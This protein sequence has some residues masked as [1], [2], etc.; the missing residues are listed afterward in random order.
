MKVLFVSSGNSEFFE[1]APFIKSQGDSLAKKGIEM[2]YFSIKGTGLKGYLKNISRLKEYVKKTNPDV[3]HTHYSLSGW[4][5]VLARTGKPMVLSLMGT[6]THGGVA[7]ISKSALST[8]LTKLQVKFIQLYYSAI[9]VKSENLRKAV[10][11][12]KACYV[13]PNGVN[14]ERFKPLDKTDCRKKLG[15]PS[16]K[17]LILFMA[18]TTDTNKNFSLLEK[19]IPFIKTENYQVVAPYPVTHQ[20]VPLYFNACDLLVF[21]S[22]KE[23]SPNV[24][25]EALACNTSIV[26]TLSGDVKER[27]EGLKRVL[28]SGFD[29]KEVAAKIDQMLATDIHEDT[30]EIIRSQIDEDLIAAKIVD[31]YN[32]IIKSGK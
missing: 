7:G 17:K 1:I 20:Q 12:K 2:D 18:K 15:L 28:I 8:Y 32:S 29:E 13:I 6:D 3:I 25:K 19:A 31:I 4:V 9:I 16:N 26:T 14:Y 21:L 23:G 24:I 27:V 30:R 22:R 11:K 10:W 5:S